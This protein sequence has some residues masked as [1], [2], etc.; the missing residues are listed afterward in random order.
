MFSSCC[1][2]AWPLR[3]A[4]NTKADDNSS[5][6]DKRSKLSRLASRSL[7]SSP[8]SPRRHQSQQHH[9]LATPDAPI[10]PPTGSQDTTAKVVTLINTL[11]C[12][13]LYRNSFYLN[14]F[15][16]LPVLVLFQSV[17]DD[18]VPPIQA[19]TSSPVLAP[20]RQKQQQQQPL[21]S[22]SS[23]QSEKEHLVVSL[24]YRNNRSQD[25]SILAKLRYSP[26]MP[27]RRRG[28][29]ESGFFR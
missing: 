22:T 12:C 2:L 13:P 23:E 7:P 26:L 25:D 3:P 28:S 11:L 14:F 9:L 21:L 5:T 24:S 29:S 27:L 8:A 19:S 16:H 18:L 15:N 6:N 4:G 17:D 1:E 20:A 10:T